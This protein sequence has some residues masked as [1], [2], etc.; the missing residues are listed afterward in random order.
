LKKRV[1]GPHKCVA[2]DLALLYLEESI[3]KN[4]MK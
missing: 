4:K 2:S 3:L 1:V